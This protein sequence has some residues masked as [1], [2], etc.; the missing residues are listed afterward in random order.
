VRIIPP[1][2]DAY[3]DWLKE[4]PD[5]RLNLV[6]ARSERLI[7]IYTRQLCARSEKFG[8]TLVKTDEP[9]PFQRYP[10]KNRSRVLYK[11]IFSEDDEIFYQLKYAGGFIP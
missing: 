2:R 9:D 7:D 10:T 3:R 11:P 6:L 8:F 4:E 1:T 5:S